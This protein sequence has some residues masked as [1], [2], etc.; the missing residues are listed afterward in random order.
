[1]Y[2]ALLAIPSISE[3]DVLKVLQKYKSKITTGPDGIPCFLL[4]DCASIYTAP[5][6]IIFNIPLRT[7]CFPHIWKKNK[8]S[9][10]FSN[11]VT[12]VR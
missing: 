8:G 1:M 4:K 7:P 5:L 2:A 6:S 9:A 11:W 10:L 12:K 3:N